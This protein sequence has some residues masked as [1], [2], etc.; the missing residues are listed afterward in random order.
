MWEMDDLSKTESGNLDQLI[1]EMSKKFETFTLDDSQG[2]FFSQGHYHGSRVVGNSDKETCE[3]YFGWTRFFGGIKNPDIGIPLCIGLL[4]SKSRLVVTQTD[5][6]PILNEG[7]AHSSSAFSTSALIKTVEAVSVALGDNDQDSSSA[8]KKKFVRRLKSYHSSPEVNF[9][10]KIDERIW[11][12]TDLNFL[13]FC[14]NQVSFSISQNKESGRN[15]KINK[16]ILEDSKA[17]YLS[18]LERGFL[19]ATLREGKLHSKSRVK[20][21][22]QFSADISPKQGST[23]FM[24]GES[25]SAKKYVH[26]DGKRYS[27]D[28]WKKLYGSSEKTGIF[29]DEIESLGEDPGDLIG[30][31]R[32]EVFSSTE[33]KEEPIVDSRDKSEGPEVMYEKA[34]TRTKELPGGITEDESLR[35]VI[36][37][38][39]SK[40]ERSKWAHTGKWR[41]LLNDR[42]LKSYSR[43]LEG[44]EW[45]MKSIKN[46]HRSRD[47]GAPTPNIRWKLHEEILS[48]MEDELLRKRR[49]GVSGPHSLLV[50]RKV[51]EDE[52]AK[53]GHSVSTA[54]VSQIMGDLNALRIIQKPHRYTE[55]NS[56]LGYRFNGKIT[57]RIQDD[58]EH[59]LLERLLDTFGNRD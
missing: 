22:P 44:G 52:L 42:F 31:V 32:Q 13:Q 25:P 15:I 19:K 6:S 45:E 36:T 27:W 24:L 34:F 56:R 29:S 35:I 16:K 41:V 43:W 2:I 57:H 1:E 48:V 50:S 20:P 23:N 7:R 49:S 21:T 53:R 5:G 55:G 14:S 8:L 33:D 46:S 54:R 4:H 37:K 40:L 11:E 30:E 9:V 10:S 51:I 3:S 28:A 12:V 38:D 58:E 59:Y 47:D 18:S 17:S 26:L 39:D